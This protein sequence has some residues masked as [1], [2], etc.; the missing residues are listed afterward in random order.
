M[1]SCFRL[2]SDQLPN[3]QLCLVVCVC[4]CERNP[5]SIHACNCIPL[6]RRSFSLKSCVAH[7]HKRLGCFCYSTIDSL[8]LTFNLRP[9]T[10]HT[11]REREREIPPVIAAD[12]LASPA[13][14]VRSCFQL[15]SDG[16]VHSPKSNSKSKE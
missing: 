12:Q 2:H 4:V 3:V 7:S 6:S 1:T 9:C 11:K 14:Q 10:S 13:S 15:S 16:S 5:H 8:T